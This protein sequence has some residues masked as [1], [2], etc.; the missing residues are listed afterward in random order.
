[1]QTT[2]T[3]EQGR[4]PALQQLDPREAGYLLGSAW[5]QE[6]SFTALDVIALNAERLRRLAAGDPHK[7]GWIAGA[8][9]VAEG[10]EVEPS[11]S[12]AARGECS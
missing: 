6:A 1:M 12:L 3:R 4:G 9:D 11:V 5:A 2:T 8:L 10:V 7:L